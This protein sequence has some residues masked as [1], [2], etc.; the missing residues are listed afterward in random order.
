MAP[1]SIFLF[2]FFVTP[3]WR[4]HLEHACALLLVRLAKNPKMVR[5][6]KT[7]ANPFALLPLSCPPVLYYQ[8]TRTLPT[9]KK[10]QNKRATKRAHEELQR[11][12]CPAAPAAPKEKEKPLLTSPL[13][14][15]REAAADLLARED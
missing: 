15:A 7:K 10:K 11:P 12:P 2:F 13:S 6:E 14:P 5:G 8:P 4:T 9:G 3:T 1:V